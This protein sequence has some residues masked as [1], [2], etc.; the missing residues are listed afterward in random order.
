MRPEPPSNTPHGFVSGRVRES[1]DGLA[2]REPTNE[3]QRQRRLREAADK[4]KAE[5]RERA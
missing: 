4:A 1:A 2:K 5:P 3:A